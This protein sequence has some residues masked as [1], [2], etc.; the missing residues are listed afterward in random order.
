MLNEYGA[1]AMRLY[2]I[3]SPVVR[4]DNL[5]F[6]K[7]GVFDVIRNVFLPWY[8]AYRFLVQ[9]VLRF[10]GE[11]GTSVNLT[12]VR[13]V[14]PGW[15]NFAWSHRPGCFSTQEFVAVWAGVQV[16]M[17]PSIYSLCSGMLCCFGCGAVGNQQC[18]PYRGP[19]MLTQATCRKPCPDRST[20]CRWIW[21]RRQTCWTAGLRPRREP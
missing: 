21:Y 9:N 20:E 5:A 13:R 2:L 7:Q 10:E 6:K 8:N 19:E 16:W 1:D 12:Q 11:A 18:C 15:E 3:T 17:G 4:G 14:T